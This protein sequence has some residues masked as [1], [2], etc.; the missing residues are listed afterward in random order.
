MFN[1]LISKAA[2]LDKAI[3][4]SLAAMLS[5]NVVVLANQLQTAPQVAQVQ[6]D[7]AQQV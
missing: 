3:A 1:N 4:L 6:G 7:T 2:P 5:F